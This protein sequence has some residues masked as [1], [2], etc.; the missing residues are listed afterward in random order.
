[1]STATTTQS[2]YAAAP[3]LADVLTQP[4][5]RGRVGTFIYRNPTI[6]IGGALLSLMVLM[7]IFAPYL[8]TVDPTALAPAK[9]TREPSSAYWFGS[10]MLRR[11]IYSRGPFW[12]RGF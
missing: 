6:V 1:M 10:D 8:G 2:G 5:T 3:A 7:A 9:R 11:A 12:T 4:T